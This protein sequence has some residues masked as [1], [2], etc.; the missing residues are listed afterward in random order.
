MGHFV[1]KDIR[2]HST[3]GPVVQS[4]RQKAPL[5]FHMRRSSMK[6]PASEQPEISAG[7]LE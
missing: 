1:P 4:G 5:H 7:S 3:D 2:D 6:T